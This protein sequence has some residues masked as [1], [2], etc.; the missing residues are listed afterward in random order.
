MSN[1]QQSFSWILFAVMAFLSWGVYGVLLNFGQM[2]MADPVNARYK[3]FF[4]IGIA[5]F[6]TAVVAPALVLLVKGAAWTMP[7]K[8]ITF[9]FLAGTVGALGAFSVLLAFGAKGPPP[10]VMS[11]VFAG[12]PIVTAIASMIVAP[13][14]GG[15]AAIRF[16]FYIGILLAATGATLVTLYRP[17]PAPP[18]RQPPPATAP[19]S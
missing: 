17:M 9:S 11:I 14:A 13:P 15:I 3:A 19:P 4:V 1:G 8:G 12:A 18:P 7:V 5:Y 2:G 16:P 10:T 6:V